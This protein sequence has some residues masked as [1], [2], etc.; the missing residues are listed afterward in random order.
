MHI[1]ELLAGVRGF[2]AATALGLV[3][4]LFVF[5]SGASTGAEL[6]SVLSA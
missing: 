3:L 6:S 1:R 4:G 2:E 5:S